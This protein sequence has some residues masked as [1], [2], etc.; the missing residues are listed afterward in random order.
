MTTNGSRALEKNLDS[1]V[2]NDLIA[3]LI[4]G[5]EFEVP[6]ALIE[7]QAQNLLNNFA[8]DLSQR[9]VDLSQ[10]DQSFVESTYN[11]M[12]GQAERDVRG[13]VL[14]EKIAELE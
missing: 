6:A 14:L 11:Q 5:N 1:R 12:K 9:G 8:Q 2:R 3:K 10:V 13:A 4:E 7:N